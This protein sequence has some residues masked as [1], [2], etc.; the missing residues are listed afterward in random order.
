MKKTI[1][2][3]LFLICFMSIKAQTY[4]DGA[5]NLE[6][7]IGYSYVESTDDPI[8]DDEYNWIW[9]GFDNANLDAIG[10]RPNTPVPVLPAVPYTPTTNGQLI[11]INIPS[12]GWVTGQNAMLFSQT[13]GVAGPAPSN[14]PQFVGLQG[15]GWEDDCF[16]CTSS[17]FLCL[18]GPCGGGANDRWEYSSSCCTS[19]CAGCSDDDQYCNPGVISST[20][21]Y[22]VTPPCS[23][24][25]NLVPPSAWVGDWFTTGCG[26]DDI[27]AEVQVRYTPPIPNSLNA[28]PSSLCGSGN[29][30]LS[31]G[32]AV[33]GGL[34]DI[35]NVTTGVWDLNVGG[36]TRTYFLSSTTTFR[37]Y[38]KNGTCRSLSYLEVTIPVN[39]IVTPI[40]TILTPTTTV[41]N[42]STVNFTS[43]TIG[44]G[45]G[46]IYEWYI[47]GVAQGNNS[48]NFSTSSLTNG[49]VVTATIT[50]NAT[51]ATPPTTI[52]NSLVFNVNPVV[53]PG[54]TA[55]TPSTS[56]CT[57]DNAVFTASPTNGGPTPSYQ[58]F[59]NG[60][61]VGTNS[62]VYSTST[63]NNGDVVTVEIT[64]SNL[65]A[66][67]LNSTSAPINMTVNPVVIPAINISASDN[68]ICSGT[69]VNFTSSVNNQGAGPIYE[70]YIN[71]I[72]QGNNSSSF[73][74]NS[75]NNGDVI[76]A[77]L[78]S[79]EVC[80]SPTNT[81]SNSIVMIVD[82]VVIPTLSITADTT[83]ICSGEN[84]T[85]TTTT[86]NGG[87]N[88]IYQW[89]INGNPVG[90]NSP[91]FTTTALSNGDIISCQLT[92]S[93]SCALPSTANSGN[94]SIT[95]NPS[96]T[97][98]VFINTSTTSICAGDAVNIS[99][100]LL[101]GGT[102]PIYDWLINGVS[103]GSSGANFNSTTINDGDIITLVV[104][105]SDACASPESVSSNS[106]S[107]NVSPVVTATVNIGSSSG[108]LCEGTPITFI[109]TSSGTG[110]NPIYNWSVN[111]SPVGGNNSVYTSFP[112]SAGDLVQVSVTPDNPCASNTTALSNILTIVPS[113]MVSAGNDVMITEG[114]SI[115]LNGSSNLPGLYN[116]NPSSSLDD[117][118]I[119]NPT[120]SP[121]TTTE[122]TLIVTTN[123]GCFGEDKVVVQVQENVVIYSSF[124]PNNDGVNDTWIIDHISGYPTCSVEIFNRWGNQVFRSTGYQQ[125]WDGTYNGEPLPLGT[126]FYV[127]SLN[128]GTEPL[129]G[130]VTILK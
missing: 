113:P 128:N 100:T 25:D 123:D 126:Y 73:S 112:L 27:G 7:W 116:W 18:G 124:T 58:W 70:W 130:T 72:A 110:L 107:F 68:V 99:S 36:P 85:F 13:Y 81:S 74:S 61:P 2:L 16:S 55:A 114:Q 49:D 10:N 44:G 40:M 117:P 102:T 30:T 5:M 89:F 24:I 67:P 101:N 118:S 88:P 120:A 41:C 83:I 17:G 52:S 57:G 65:C 43:S 37:V 42:G 50:S 8:G 34:Y 29:V 115:Q 20:I 111:S 64:S 31:F 56:I 76:E 92:S 105:S 95:V 75:L 15:E 78:I 11:W 4:N 35:L 62:N 3:F 9:R 19:L 69:T 106:L 59:V 129:Q 33:Y 80:A 66:N 23:A 32:G 46:P 93:D 91:V 104:Q 109:A 90:S 125:P 12:S 60:N 84:V 119:S 14:V 38:T 127:I 103:S 63:L 97:P 87:M 86:N 121:T 122:Y 6:M 51:C 1:I 22:R 82:S 39:P 79:N 45:A 94:I 96:V 98:S 71:G 48:T 77:S 54:V 28:S 108:L 21:D 53:A 26:G 47:N